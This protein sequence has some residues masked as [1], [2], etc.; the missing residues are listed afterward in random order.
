MAG[1]QLR[2]PAEKGCEILK[3]VKWLLQGVGL[4]SKLKLLEKF[5]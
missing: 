5:L 4:E 1:I 3:V 2:M